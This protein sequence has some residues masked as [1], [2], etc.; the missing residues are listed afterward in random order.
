MSER[1]DSSESGLAELL[2]EEGD[3]LSKLLG[4]NI[5]DDL[6]PASLHAIVEQFTIALFGPAMI[7]TGTY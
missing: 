4:V 2:K 3:Q 5:Q 1:S 7:C 6:N